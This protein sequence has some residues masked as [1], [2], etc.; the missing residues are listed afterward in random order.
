MW[1][2]LIRNSSKSPNATAAPAVEVVE[3]AACRLHTWQQEVLLLTTSHWLLLI[4]CNVSPPPSIGDW[5]RDCLLSSRSSRC[6]YIVPSCLGWGYFWLLPCLNPAAI[7]VMDYSRCLSTP[8]SSPPPDTLSP[9]L[10]SFS[11]L[12]F[13]SHASILSSWEPSGP[14]F[15]FMFC[16]RWGFQLTLQRPIL[17]FHH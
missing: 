10:P 16:I 4:P 2:E 15:L 9:R 11:P 3:A 8:T 1:N 6:S 5:Q 17:E 14:P 7:I 12:P 13:P